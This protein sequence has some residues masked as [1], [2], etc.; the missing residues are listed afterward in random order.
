[1]PP[2]S[3]AVSTGTCDLNLVL[4]L[5]LNPEECNNVKLDAQ[6]YLES[7]FVCLSLSKRRPEAFSQSRRSSFRSAPFP[8]RLTLTGYLCVRS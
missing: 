2:D 8:G 4:T 3:A 7:K 5:E 1:M 6:E